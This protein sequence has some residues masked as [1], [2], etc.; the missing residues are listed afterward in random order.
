MCPCRQT[1]T[2][3]FYEFLKRY[4][5]TLDQHEELLK[6]CDEIGIMYLCTPFSLKA[7]YELDELGVP[8]FKIGSGEMDDIPTLRAI[9]KLEK[10]MIV[11]TGMATFEEIERTYAAL[12]S[13]GISF[14]LMNCLSEYPHVMKM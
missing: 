3:L 14:A 12:S 11:S 5:L 1:S 2:F 8:A 6:H 13:S 9:A 10:P 4:A 7:A